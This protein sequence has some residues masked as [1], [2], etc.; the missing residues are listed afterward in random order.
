MIVLDTVTHVS[1]AVP[2]QLKTSSEFAF[3]DSPPPCGN[4]IDPE[5]HTRRDSLRYLRSCPHGDPR[6]RGGGCSESK[7]VQKLVEVY[8]RRYFSTLAEHSV[9]VRQL[10]LLNIKIGLHEGMKALGVQGSELYRKHTYA[11]PALGAGNS[12]V[13]PT[14][15]TMG[16]LPGEADES[17]LAERSAHWGPNAAGVRGVQKEGSPGP[18][19]AV[20]SSCSGPI[21]RGGRWGTPFKVRMRHSRMPGGMCDNSWRGFRCERPIGLDAYDQGAGTAA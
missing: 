5:G 19:W 21:R 1:D 3:E 6:V 4:R 11:A 15:Q 16:A 9:K 14:F 13:T 2:K 7:K 10:L 8:L 18:G 20:G 12:M 17:S